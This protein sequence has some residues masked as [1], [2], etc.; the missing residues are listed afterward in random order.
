MHKVIRVELKK[1]LEGAIYPNKLSLEQEGETALFLA[2]TVLK[3]IEAGTSTKDDFN[4][5]S[6]HFLDFLVDDERGY[7]VGQ[8]LKGFVLNRIIENRFGE[9]ENRPLEEISKLFIENLGL[10]NASVENI[11]GA[12]FLI[13]FSEGKKIVGK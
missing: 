10:Q 6:T 4:K 12:N 9:Y 11:V 1:L 2:F 8:E 7:G 3:S 13:T 5:I